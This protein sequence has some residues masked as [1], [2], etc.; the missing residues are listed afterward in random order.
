[1]LFRRLIDAELNRLRQ[2]AVACKC[3]RLAFDRQCK[4]AG[5]LTRLTLHGVDLGACWFRLELQGLW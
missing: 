4:R 3:H 5:C 2:K 1:M